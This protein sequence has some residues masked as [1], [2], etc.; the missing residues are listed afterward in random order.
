MTRSD[1]ARGEGR[2]PGRFREAEERGRRIARPLLWLT[3]IGGEVDEELM[4]RLGAALLQRDEPGAALAG[5]MGLPDGTAGR[6]TRAQVGAA[7]RAAPDMPEG[8]PEALRSF[9][10][11]VVAVPDWVDWGRVESGAATFR[12]L[13]RNSGDVLTLLS[14][15]GGYRFGGPADLLVLTGGLADGRTLRRLGET[16]AWSHAVTRPGG[17]R[18]G[19]EGWRLT[20]HVRVMHAL[21]NAR[22]AAR[23]DTGRWGCPISQADQ[24]ATLGLFDATVIAGCLVLGVRLTRR[25]RDDLMHLW[26]YVGWLMG[27]APQWLTDDENVRHRW[28]YHILLAAGGQSRAGQELARLTMDAQAERA[29]GHRAPAVERLHQRY[30]RARQLSMLTAFVGLPG[31]RDL[32]LR[33]RLPWAVPLAQ[34]RNVVRYR[35][36]G[37]LPGGRHRLEERGARAQS[38]YLASLFPGGDDAAVARLPESA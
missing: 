1:A 34:T 37:S 23:W 20:V 32:G 4:E 19:A 11:Q 10:E 25:Q 5:A 6:V 31:M 38:E 27:V 14:L 30:E 24:A 22:F 21:V 26:R 36:L 18:P 33:P 29:F 9:L 16:A 8:L 7:L 28:N 13:G 15:V 12:S 35:V 17:L 2:F 3:G